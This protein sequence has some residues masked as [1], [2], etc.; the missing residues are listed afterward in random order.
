MTPL[1]QGLAAATQLLKASCGRHRT[2]VVVTDGRARQ[3]Q[4]TVEA[5]RQLKNAGDRVIALLVPKGGPAEAAA[6]EESMCRIASEPCVDNVLLVR[7]FERLAGDL[8]RFLSA[9]CP[10]A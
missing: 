4:A 9:V 10:V 6:A 5:A 3:L 7:G 1:V 2:V 8:G